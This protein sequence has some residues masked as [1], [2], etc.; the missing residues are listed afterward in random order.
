MAAK[1]VPRLS[2]LEWLEW[3]FPT[4]DSAR[5]LFEQLVWP[6]SAHC[7]LCGSAEV[8]RFRNRARK[9]RPGLYECRHC[10]GQFTV[11]TKTPMSPSRLSE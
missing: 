1:W 10:S 11:T 2:S 9:S 4:E 6:N 8:W 7:P 5:R 3:K